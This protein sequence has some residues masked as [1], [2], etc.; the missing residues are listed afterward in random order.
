MPK[1]LR[2]AGTVLSASALTAA[3]LIALA[4]I[5]VPK[6]LGATPY[7]VLTASMEPTMSPGTLAIVQPID[8]AEIGVGDVITY[9]IAPGR[10]EV[11]T[12]RVVGINANSGGGHTF[13]TQG[14]ANSQPDAEPVLPVQ[15]RG[16]VAYSVPWLG[17]INSAVNSGTRSHLLLTGAG[18]LIA[19]GLWQLGSGIYSRR[20]APARTPSR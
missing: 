2:T 5:I 10:P 15:V 8:T 14:D 1:P 13:I 16:A 11:S 4:T 19:Y 18:A 20:Q 12:H 17:H 7:T 3:I 6:L 9:Q